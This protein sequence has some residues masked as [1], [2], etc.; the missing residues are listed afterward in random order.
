MSHARRA[1]EPKTGGRRAVEW[2]SAVYLIGLVL[3]LFA[4]QL[5]ADTSPS[6]ALISTFSPFLFLPALLLP[7]ALVLFRSTTIL[8]ICV[9]IAA[10]F[11]VTYQPVPASA[12]NRT[13]SERPSLSMMTFNLSVTTPAEQLAT[14]IALEDRDIV[15][16]QELTP[17]SAALLDSALADQYPYRI[18]DLQ[19]GTVGLLSKMPIVDYTWHY[20]PV[21]R[22]FIQALIDWPF[23]PVNL[24]AVHFS[25]PGIIWIRPPFLPGGIVNNNLEIEIASL[26]QQTL[27]T[28]GPVVVMGDFN[29]SDQSRAYDTIAGQLTDAFRE[30]GFGL[31]LTFPNDLSLGRIPI[32]GPLVRIDYTFH[33]PHLQA[34]KA[35]VNCVEGQS[36]HC[37][38]LTTFQLN[39][40]WMDR[41][42]ASE[43]AAL[44]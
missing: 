40:K 34:S 35:T 41:R 30:A 38:L 10:L 17:R 18:L 26:L 14:T 6:F 27:L 39:Q 24:F 11:L 1:F 25:S 42:S 21:G 12:F 3:V 15:A 31:G 20:P 5:F 7:V 2:L 16:V 9:A 8:G 36:D 37:A 23:S 44:R 13:A 22:P 32:P 4:S 19:A 29:M 43:T 28:P 33:S